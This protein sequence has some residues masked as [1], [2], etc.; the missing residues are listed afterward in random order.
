MTAALAGTTAIDY[1]LFS[2]IEPY[3]VWL[4]NIALDRNAGIEC[5]I[6]GT[7]ADRSY[8][9]RINW[10]ASLPVLDDN[11]PLNVPFDYDARVRIYNNTGVAINNYQSRVV[12][13]AQKYSVA[14]KLSLGISY[15][16]L[17]EDEKPLADKYHI[18]RKIQGGEL[19]MK[20]PK[21]D[22]QRTLFENYS[23]APAINIEN[24]L[25]NRAC[26]RGYK[27]VLTKVWSNQPAA[28]FGDLEIR[29]YQDKVL[30][31]TL[32]PYCL[33]DLSTVVRHIPPLELW[34]P[35]I[36]EMRVA[37]TS[38]T[39]H[40]GIIAGAEIEYRRLTIWDKI[41]W[42]LTKMPKITT[43]AERVM[44][45]ELDLEDKLKAGIY[46][47]VTPLPTTDIV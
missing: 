43:G 27:I 46:D 1:S 9:D 47:L 42:G 30:V 44:I 39:G 41:S 32:F 12:W 22:L 31:L 29:I 37:L 7:V 28:N 13:E 11:L 3:L 36:S 16:D 10:G 4:R 19:P 6:D 40:A 35:A 25:I 17:F 14:D 18:M 33:P 2:V 38:T 26:P 45:S 21:G 34:I 23:G 8:E 15:A 24:N 5:W 20:Y